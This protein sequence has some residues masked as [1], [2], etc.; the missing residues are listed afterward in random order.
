MKKYKLNTKS[1]CNSCA[2]TNTC[3]LTVVDNDTRI[4]RACAA[5]IPRIVKS[6]AGSHC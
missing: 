2:K 6:N 3:P 4:V 5:H 1:I